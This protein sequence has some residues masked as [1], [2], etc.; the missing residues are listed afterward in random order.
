MPCGRGEYF[1]PSRRRVTLLDR[2]LQFNQHVIT[3][4]DKNYH[5]VRRLKI[6]LRNF[7]FHK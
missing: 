5:L 4:I 3:F 2:I 6:K 1:C 7:K